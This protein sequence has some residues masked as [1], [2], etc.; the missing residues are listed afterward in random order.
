MRVTGDHVHRPYLIWQAGIM[1]RSPGCIDHTVVAM[2]VDGTGRRRRADDVLM[3]DV[4]EHLVPEGD[5]S[6]RQPARRASS[7]H[8]AGLCAAF[9][10]W[11]DD[12]GLT[13]MAERLRFFAPGQHRRRARRPRCRRG[14]SS[15]P[16]P[17]GERCPAG[18]RCWP[19]WRRLVHDRPEADHRAAGRDAAHV[20]ARRL[21]DGQPRHPPRRAHDPAGLGLPGAGPACWDLCWYLALNRARLPEPKEAAIGRFR[22]ALER[23]GDRHRRLVRRPARPVPDRHHGHLRL[24][25]G[26]RRR[27]RAAPGGRAGRR[28]CRRPPGHRRSPGQP[29]EQPTTTP[30]PPVAGRR[31]PPSSTARSPPSSSP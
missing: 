29:G 12:I 9:W 25:E 27:R 2:E 28:R 4:G 16:T 14:R 26:P 15:P 31:A 13:T 22:A 3:R 30:V 21:E 10:G 8:L 6:C 7:T 24:G 19:A 11:H 1:D 20:P 18:H 5:T 23:H 17:D